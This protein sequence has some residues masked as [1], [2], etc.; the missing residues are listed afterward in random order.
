MRGPPSGALQ[1]AGGGAM[2]VKS[3]QCGGHAA[4]V[5]GPACKAGAPPRRIPRTLLRPLPSGHD[6]A[7]ECAPESLAAPLCSVAKCQAEESSSVVR[8]LRTGGR[9]RTREL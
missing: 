2:K 1:H 4:G 7:G 9:G 6:A 5:H 3:R 8:C